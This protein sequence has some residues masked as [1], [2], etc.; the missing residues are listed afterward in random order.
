MADVVTLA[1]LRRVRGSLRVPGDKSISHRA[2]IFAALADGPSRLEGLADGADVRSTRGAI[3][4]LGVPTRDE[5]DGG[6]IVDGRGFA[7]L[8]RDPA[9]PPLTIDCGNSGTTTRLL[10][11]LLAGRRGRFR[12]VGDA[13]LSRR[14]MRRVVEPLRAMGARIHGGETLPL[15]IEG[16]PLRAVSH[17]GRI[18]SAQVKSAL[19]LAGLQAEGATRV[20][21]PSLSRDHTERMLAAMGAPLTASDEESGRRRVEVRGGGCA[22]APVNVLVPGDPSSAAFATALACL[23]PESFVTVEN[24]SVNPTRLGFYRVLRRMGGSV[25]WSDAA[26]SGSAAG[27]PAGTIH[28]SSSVLHATEVRGADTVDAIDEVPLIAVVACHATGVTEIRDARELR[29]KE[30]DRVAATARL[31]RAFGARV[32]ERPDGLAVHGPASLVGA[33]V[34]AEHDHRIAMCAAVCAATATGTTRLHGAEWVAVSY[35]GFFDTLE[36]LASA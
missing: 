31:L 14:P 10:I 35:P 4:A 23:L 6:V 24:V 11:G 1:S 28:A 19:V 21:E 25:T 2:L 3:E 27:E 9:A 5:P 8:D 33:N 13:S 36:R 7:G 26:S 32:D 30:S 20:T 15:E 34:D 29:V 17:E 22:L 16:A 18:A 12:L